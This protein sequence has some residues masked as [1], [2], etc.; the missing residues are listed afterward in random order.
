MFPL[1]RLRL[2]RL[3]STSKPRLLKLELFLSRLFSG[4][5]DTRRNHKTSVGAFN[6]VCLVWAWV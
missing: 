5:C 4:K 2:K 3:K 1:A 6:P